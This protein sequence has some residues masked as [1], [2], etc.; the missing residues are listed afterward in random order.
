MSE[1]L[2]AD[3]LEDDEID[4]GA[5][6]G[7]L[8]AR[9]GLIVFVTFVA[10]ALGVA[11]ALVTPS[12]YQADALLQL[13]KKSGG[14]LAVSADLSALFGEPPQTVAEIEILKSRLILGKTIENLDLTV[15]ATPRRLPVIGDLLR[16]Y[17][18][19]DPGWGFLAPFAWYG[20]EI[21]LGALEVPKGLEGEA[22]TLTALGDGRYRLDA[23][24]GRIW[25]VSLAR[26]CA[27]PKAGWC[28]W[29]TG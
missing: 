27:T 28:C 11:Y 2:R 6:F 24:N 4:L 19:P 12:V 10:V 15:S 8:Y 7:L 20:E 26:P 23:G 14:G 5:L 9:K 25:K 16:R 18:V 13:E 29:W 3:R 1:F 21:A 17:Q 22:L